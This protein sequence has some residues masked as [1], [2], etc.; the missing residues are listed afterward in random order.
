MSDDKFWHNLD[1]H[2]WGKIFSGIFFGDKAN[3]FG[4]QMNHS[5]SWVYL[6]NLVFVLLGLF[7]EEL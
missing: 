1:D 3:S 2:L 4:Q 6:L 5:L 7:V